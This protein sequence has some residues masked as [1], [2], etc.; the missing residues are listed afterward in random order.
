MSIWDVLIPPNE[1]QKVKIRAALN[2]NE[3]KLRINLKLL[4]EW[5]ESQSYLPKN[6]D[7]RILSAYIRGSKH[8]LEDAK[9]KIEKY[10][11]SKTL[12]PDLFNKRV[13]TVEED[14]K[15]LNFM[16]SVTMPEIT[17]EGYRITI[18]KI[19]NND[20]ET[21]DPL[22]VLR[23]AALTCELRCHE[24]NF[25]AGEIIV[26]DCEFATAAIG[27]KMIASQLKKVIVLVQEAFPVLVKQVHLITDQMIFVNSA[28][29]LKQFMKEK[30]RNRFYVHKDKEDLKK[31]IDS[32]CLPKDFGGNQ[33]SLRELNEKWKG[34]LVGYQGLFENIDRVV[35]EGP[36]PKND[37]SGSDDCCLEGS[38]RQLNFD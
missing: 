36:V 28:N 8:I 31:F 37:W 2:E 9:K 24:E 15:A 19:F 6:Y 18:L 7:K 29:L 3:D 10:F 20:I 34:I 26:L 38:F 13:L 14:L 30:I 25:L 11:I 12:H 27:A 4:E 16:Y 23:L 22:K 5:I 21:F 17:Q 1:E 35:L 32:K 33:L